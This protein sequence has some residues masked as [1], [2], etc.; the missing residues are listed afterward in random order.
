MPCLDVGYFYNDFGLEVNLLSFNPSSAP[1]GIGNLRIGDSPWWLAGASS[2]S[3]CPRW[4]SSWRTWGSGR[5]STSP[6][7]ACRWIYTVQCALC[8]QW[9]QREALWPLFRRVLHSQMVFKRVCKGLL[10][11]PIVNEGRTFLWCE[12]LQATNL[13]HFWLNL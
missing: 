11:R 12:S 7:R 9:L 4:E 5:R 8:T 10:R 3:S 1:G 13:F 2:R 6:A